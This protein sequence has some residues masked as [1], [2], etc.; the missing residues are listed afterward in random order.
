[1][2]VGGALC[3]ELLADEL[4]ADVGAHA[5]AQRS[6]REVVTASRD[7]IACSLLGGAA[8]DILLGCWCSADVRAPHALTPTLWLLLALAG[9]SC[10]RAPEPPDDA[11][12]ILPLRIELDERPVFV[13]DVVERIEADSYV[14]LR[15]S[16]VSDT[17]TPELVP[18]AIE[19]WV[20][21]EGEAPALGERIRVRSL[22]RRSGVWEPALE[23]DFD[24]LEYVAVIGG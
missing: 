5:L 17:A 19:R 20:A 1:M 2:R 13:G 12:S 18:H 24:A 9:G 3:G 11:R 6:S 8:G 16:I 7:R 4:G 10:S 21:V 22:A 14:Y 23:R 15:L